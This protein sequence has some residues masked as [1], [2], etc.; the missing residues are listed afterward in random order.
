[1]TAERRY[2]PEHLRRLFDAYCSHYWLSNWCGLGLPAR[3]RRQAVDR[4]ALRPGMAVL[5]LMAGTGETW[6]AILAGIGASGN[7]SAIDFSHEMAA[8][9][10]RSANRFPAHH[11][12]ILEQD[13]FSFASP[14]GFDAISCAFGVKLL[15]PARAGEFAALVSRQLVPGGTFSLLELTV[16]AQP[17]MRQVQHAMV[18]RLIPGL[19]RALTGTAVGVDQLDKYLSGFAGFA[20]LQAAFAAA[21]LRSSVTPLCMG[22]A[23][24][25]HG[26]KP[27]HAASVVQQ[28]L[29]A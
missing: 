1:M 29:V 27:R 2:E 28:R 24:I 21:G 25:M 19:S 26:C 17:G 11:V 9:A 20:P 23:A 4:L 14:A 8:A 10:R 5:D 15:P 22:F 18:S 16:P 7:L 13:I 12:R 3:W 6:P